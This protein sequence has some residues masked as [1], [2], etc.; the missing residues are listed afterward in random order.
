M[1]VNQQYKTYQKSG[2]T[3][4]FKSW[5]TRENTKKTIGADSSVNEEIDKNI[6]VIKKNDK[7]NTTVLGFPIKTAAIAAG[8]ILVAVIAVAVIRK[9][10]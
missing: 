2:G 8:I 6:S 1:T 4:D 10:D 9:K 3:L 5:L 7:M